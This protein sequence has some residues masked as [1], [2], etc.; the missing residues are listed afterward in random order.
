MLHVAII[1]CVAAPF[2]AY[3]RVKRVTMYQLEGGGAGVGAGVDLAPLF[4]VTQM[5]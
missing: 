3:G 4:P 1:F 5:L 2:W